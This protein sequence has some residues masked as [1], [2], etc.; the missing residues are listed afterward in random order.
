VKFGIPQTSLARQA[1]LAASF[2]MAWQVAAKATRDTLF[3][4]VYE[5]SALPAAVGVSAIFSILIAILTA[6]LMRS[7]GPARVIPGAYL[8]G[9]L[10]HGV[11][12]LLLPQFPRAIG[13]FVYM[14]VMSLGP[15]LLSGFWALANERFDAREARRRFG[16]I[17]AFGTL[18]AVAG[19][20]LGERVSALG[21][22]GG[23]LLLLA[24]LQLVCGLTMFRF[25]PPGSTEF[26]HES[27]SIPDVISGAPYLVGLICFVLLTSM[28]AATLDYLFK[29]NAYAEFGNGPGLGRFFSLFYAVTSAVTFAVQAVVSR[30]WLKRFG[31]GGTVAVLPIAVTGASLMSLLFPGAIGVIIARGLEQ[32]LRGSL[33]RSGYELFYT[34]MPADE[35]RTTKPVIDIGVDRLGDGLAAAAMSFAIYFPAPVAS[36]LILGITAIIAAG[37]AWLAFRLDKAYVAV[38]ER[39]LAKQAISI[40]PDEAEDILTKSVALR[41]IAVGPLEAHGSTVMQEATPAA[42]PDPVLLRLMELRSGNA[43]RVRAALRGPLEPLLIPQVIELLGQDDVARRAHELLVENGA[44][45]TGVLVDSLANTAIPFK[46]RRRI[47]RI[48]AGAGN[49]IAWEGLLAQLTDQ[50]FDIRYRCGRALEKIRQRHP[51]YCPNDNMILEI[52]GRE[53]S[54]HR[55]SGFSPA[56]RPASAGSSTHNLPPDQASQ[57]LTHISNLLALV[58]PPQSIGL[59]FRALLTDDPKLRATA[60]EYLDSVLPESLRD[61]IAAQFELPQQAPR[62]AKKSD[63][64]LSQL[65]EASP[66][67]MAKLAE[68][69]VKEDRDA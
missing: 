18:G 3:L 39:G 43:P 15:V 32:L 12:Y 57:R 56:P 63:E 68:L 60:L 33:Y 45:V 5:P 40:V 20:L 47:P 66:S 9:A 16:Q 42:A 27:Q 52:V 24:A 10:L 6:R 48:L 26:S 61:Q 2:M 59:A 31:P 53:L 25:A 7:Y 17:T 11:E 13:A 65:M 55:A 36:R 21:I 37:A 4:A 49:R 28:S 1:V 44:K 50:S 69:G 34:P 29:V 30:M 38:L 41:S 46:V 19:G 64:A 58:L 22:D 62:P 54:A 51:D 14:H 8:A 23:L 67:I 35:K